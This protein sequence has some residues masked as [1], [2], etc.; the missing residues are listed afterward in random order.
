MAVSSPSSSSSSSHLLLLAQTRA[1][2]L[3]HPVGS[4]KP[5]GLMLRWEQKVM[6]RCC[7]FCQSP[8]SA[9]QRWMQHILH[10]QDSLT[11]KQH[12]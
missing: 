12:I 5:C 8:K 2:S 7:P 6:G 11:N 1:W 4:L 9:E 3:A 10:L